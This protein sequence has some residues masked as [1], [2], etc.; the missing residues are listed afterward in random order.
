MLVRFMVIPNHTYLILKMPAPNGVLSI[1]GH[2]KTSYKCD[3]EAVQLTETLE[4]SAN[5]TMMLA[6]SKKE[7]VDDVVVK[8]KDKE[9]FIADLTQTFD[10]LQAYRWKLNLGKCVFCVPSGKLLGFMVSQCSIEANPVKVDAIRN[11]VQPTSKKDVM[12]LTG[13]MAA[14]SHFISKLS[15]KGLPFFKLLEKA[16]KFEWDD[17]ACKAL[18]ELKTFLFPS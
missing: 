6:E 14:P 8:T 12:K 17:K 10:S 15:E 2:V 11:M 18:E 16:D 7:Y 5:N 4:Y 9:N 3:T 13:M 1:F